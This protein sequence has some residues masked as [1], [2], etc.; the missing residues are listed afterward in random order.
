MYYRSR[1]KVEKGKYQKV[2]LDHE[3]VVLLDYGGSC[4]SDPGYSYDDCIYGVIEDRTVGELGCTVP[5]LPRSLRQGG[6]K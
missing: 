4:N 1:I 5:W 6:P 2:S 3:E